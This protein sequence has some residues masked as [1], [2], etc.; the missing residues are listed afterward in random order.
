M[1]RGRA[2]GI[3]KGRDEKEAADGSPR[4]LARSSEL[5]AQSPQKEN[6]LL[7]LALQNGPY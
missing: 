1:I 2:F 7:C 3:P 4:T 5:L 6:Q